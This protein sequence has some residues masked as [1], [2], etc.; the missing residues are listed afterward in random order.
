MRYGW[1]IQVAW[2]QLV[3]HI[4]LVYRWVATF[5]YAKY[6]DLD[7]PKAPVYDFIA[8]PLAYIGH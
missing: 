5:I 2:K 3:K 4:G 6:A 7:N 8:N 1:S